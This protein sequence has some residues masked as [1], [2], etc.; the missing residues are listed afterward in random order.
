M[1]QRIVEPALVDTAVGKRD[2]R[3]APGPLTP[4]P[5][6]G[7]SSSLEFPTPT[8]SATPFTATSICD[9]RRPTTQRKIAAN[10]GLGE[11]CMSWQ[12]EDADA[13]R[14]R[15]TIAEFGEPGG[16]GMGGCPAGPADSDPTPGTATR[17]S[18]RRPGRRSRSTGRRPTD[19]PAAGPISGYSVVAMRQPAR[20]ASRRSWA[21]ARART[22]PARR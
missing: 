5:K 22:R 8:R 21:I 14:Q 11:R 2:V 18:A 12:V 9:D 13:N 10:A 1:E 4:A 16:P 19:I 20:T 7:Y 15:L 17:P 6:G 3:A